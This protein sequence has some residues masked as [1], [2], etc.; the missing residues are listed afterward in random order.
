MERWQ[1]EQAITLNDENLQ[2]LIASNEIQLYKLSNSERQQWM[3]ALQPIYR[4]YEKQSKKDYLTQLRDEIRHV[5][6]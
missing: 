6:N 3:N 2:Q 1:H 4:S 5:N